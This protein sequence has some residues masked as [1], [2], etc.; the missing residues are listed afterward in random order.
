MQGHHLVYLTAVF[1]GKLLQLRWHEGSVVRDQFIPAA[2]EVLKTSETG[3]GDFELT[4]RRH[5]GLA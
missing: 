2:F 1:R 4:L 5:T 3:A